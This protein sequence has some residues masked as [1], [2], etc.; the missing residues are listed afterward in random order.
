MGRPNFFV[1]AVLVGGLAAPVQAEP[2]FRLSLPIDCEPGRTCFVQNFVDVDPGPGV[3]DWR[4][5]TATYDQHSGVDI[6]VLSAAAAKAGVPVLAAAPGVVRGVRDGMTESLLTG[7][8]KQQITGR[9]CGNGVVVDHADGWQTQYCH[10]RPGSVRVRSGQAVERGTPLG[11]VGATGLAQFAHVHVT[12][13]HHGKTV[14]PYL[15]PVAEGTCRR[16]GEAVAT[17][18]WDEAAAKALAYRGGE[19]IQAGF[20][21]GG[22][23]HAKLELDHLD[24]DPPGRDKDG[25]VF[26]AR[27]IN[28]QPGD[29]IALRLTGPGNFQVSTTTEPMDRSKATYMAFGGRRRPPT[30]WATG[31]YRGQAE[32]LRSGTVAGRIEG[33]FE[34]K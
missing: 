13:R 15:G 7:S 30:G 11:H 6:R 27:A 34:L 9:D 29:R 24:V 20:A 32:I 23:P 2:A 17:G 19:F 4:C 14:D 31:T 16:D 21:A 26:F 10:M 28:L 12:V 25:L 18:L 5:G 1:F 22:F 8:D 3:R 33:T